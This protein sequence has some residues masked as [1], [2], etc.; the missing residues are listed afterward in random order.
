[1]T[2]S[3]STFFD[4]LFWIIVNIHGGNLLNVSGNTV[5][6]HQPGA[7]LTSW[8]IVNIYFITYLFSNLFINE[9]VWSKKKFNLKSKIMSS[10]CCFCINNNVFIYKDIKQTH[11][12]W[13]K[14]C[15]TLTCCTGLVELVKLSYWCSWRFRL[16]V[17][18]DWRQLSD[19]FAILHLINLLAVL[20]LWNM[21][22]SLTKH[23]DSQS[24]AHFLLSDIILTCWYF[25]RRNKMW[26]DLKHVEIINM[27]TQP[28][29]AVFFILTFFLQHSDE[30][31]ID[32]WGQNFN[33]FNSQVSDKIPVKLKT[34]PSSVL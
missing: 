16:V 24:W 15:L 6:L 9:I 26:L 14:Y 19:S 20:R 28:G 13:L 8:Q 2:K 29:N 33:L 34:F 31:I 23:L 27:E 25:Y 17:G 30:L 3:I 21:E 7:R 4:L 22:S 10:N 11:L 1:M 12:R 32:S 18:D 5:A